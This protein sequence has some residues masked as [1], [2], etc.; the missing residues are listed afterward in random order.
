MGAVE[1]RLGAGEVDAHSVDLVL[2]LRP[3]VPAH[4]HCWVSAVAQTMQLFLLVCQC[5]LWRGGR[6]GGAGRG[7]SG[8]RAPCIKTAWLLRSTRVLFLDDDGS[9]CTLQPCTSHGC[10]WRYRSTNV[11]HTPVCAHSTRDSCH[12]LPCALNHVNGKQARYMGVLQ[13][14]QTCMQTG[15]VKHVNAHMGA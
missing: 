7:E 11:R 15:L 5:L 12:Q 14:L 9:A 8:W 3:P 4:P 1:G 6:R 10:E 13:Q 2:L